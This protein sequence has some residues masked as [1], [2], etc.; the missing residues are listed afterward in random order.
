VAASAVQQERTRRAQ[1]LRERKRRAAWLKRV[2]QNTD[3]WKRVVEQGRGSGVVPTHT[4][5]ELIKDIMSNERCNVV[6]THVNADFDSFAGA[7]GICS[8]LRSRRLMPAL[9]M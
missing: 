6:L 9:S 7:A 4:S 2:E 3:D 1:W 5:D 8:R